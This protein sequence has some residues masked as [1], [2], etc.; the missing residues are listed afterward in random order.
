MADFFTALRLPIIFYAMF[1]LSQLSSSMIL[2]ARSVRYCSQFFFTI[3]H[4]AKIRFN[5][6]EMGPAA[7]NEIKLN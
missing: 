6:M 2:V 4:A 1:N 7:A 5:Q 3:F